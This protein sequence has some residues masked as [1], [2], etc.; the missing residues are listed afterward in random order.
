MMQP[1]LFRIAMAAAVLALGACGET[2]QDLT[3]QGVKQD[4]APYTGVG[5]SQYAQAGWKVG[6]KASWEQQLKARAQY[7]QNDYTRMGAKP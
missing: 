5:T 2:P 7:G 4:D 6:D 1:G 3:G